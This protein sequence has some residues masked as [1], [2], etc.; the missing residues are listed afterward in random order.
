MSLHV[1][2]V[3]AGFTG[4]MLAVELQRLGAVQATLIERGPV[5]GLG[6]AYGAAHPMHLLNVRASNM[7]AFADRPDHLV[8]WLE[9]RGYASAGDMFAP[10]QV[11]GEYLR[12]ILGTAEGATVHQVQGAVA[13]VEKR[14]GGVLLT[15][16]DGTTIAA[17]VAV[18]A[19]GNLP[20][21]TLPAIAAADLPQGRYIHDPWA[22]GVAEGLSDGDTIL[23]LGTGLT[24]VDQALLLDAAGFRGRMVAVSRRGLLPRSHAAPEAWAKI[25]RAP[26]GNLSERVRQVRERAEEVG[27]R[28]AVDE[29]RP[30]SQEMW[31][32][33]PRAEQARFLRHL[34]AW[35]DVHRHRIAPEVTKRIA[36]LQASGRLDVHAGRIQSVAETGAGAEVEWTPRGA[37]APERLAVQRIIN[38]TGPATDLRRT[39]DPLL[40][41]LT[42]RGT[43]RPDPLGMGIDVA[44]GG[45][46]LA[47]TGVPN[48]WLLSLGPM[49]R[50]TYWEI[51]AV[52]DI[53]VQVADTAQRLAKGTAVPPPHLG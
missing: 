4:L 20:P 5:H 39:P 38:C 42:E 30:F 31:Q 51:V 1:A 11:F 3:G 37:S 43:I 10:R 44:D 7:S 19:V 28:N 9:R 17:D 41:R 14:S 27:W 21:L 18:L 32:Q 34:R 33:L 49:S 45:R 47:A 50:G 23:I 16:G 40:R 35:W 8:R 15:L 52:P 13:D 22:P 24:M 25:E 26:Q 29:L 12:E 46:T 6:V 36:A 53:R 2:I 48:D